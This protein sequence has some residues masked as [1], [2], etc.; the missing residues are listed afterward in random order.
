MQWCHWWCCW[1]HIMCMPAS[2]VPHDQKCHVASHFSCLDLRNMVPLTTSL[3]S[4]DT[5]TG[6]DGLNGQKIDVMPPS[7][8]LDLKV[9]N[10]TTNDTISITWHWFQHQWHHMII[11][12]MLNLI[13]VVLLYGKQWY[14]W[15]CWWHH[16]TLMPVQMASNYQKLMLHFIQCSGVTDNTIS[17][18]MWGLVPLVSHDQKFMLHISDHLDL[19]NAMAPLMILSTLYDANTNAVMPVASHDK[20]KSCCTS[21]QLSWPKECI[22]DIDD[23]VGTMWHW[24]L[25]NDI[26]W[27]KSGVAPHFNCLDLR[28]A[29]VPFFISLPSCDANNSPNVTHYIDCH[30]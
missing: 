4:C 2:V 29:M 19:R 25:A 16:V 30:V 24:C 26:K 13:S 15:W 18:M 17:I 8:P 23:A 10:G 11:K 22:V 5:N 3:A 12:V 14:H 9:F 21:F 20:E 6:I 7:N 28:N 27:P 1:H